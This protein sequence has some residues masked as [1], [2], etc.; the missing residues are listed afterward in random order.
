[1]DVFRCCQVVALWSSLVAHRTAQRSQRGS[2]D[3]GV[4]SFPTV[5]QHVAPLAPSYRLPGCLRLCLDSVLRRRLALRRLCCPFS[6]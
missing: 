3:P 2:S 6:R 4:F 5:G 1:M